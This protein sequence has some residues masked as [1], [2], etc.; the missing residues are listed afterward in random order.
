VSASSTARPLRPVRRPLR[1][2][3]GRG[4]L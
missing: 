1:P 2:L 4:R 3:A